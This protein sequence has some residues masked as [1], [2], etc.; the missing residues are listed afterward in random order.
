MELA[1]RNRT[2]KSSAGCSALEVFA[3]DPAVSLVQAYLRLNGFFT[4]TE[5]PVMARS[6]RGTF[7]MTD[8]DIL[9]VRFPNAQH[10]IPGEGVPAAQLGRDRALEIDSQSMQL[11]IGEVKEGRAWINRGALRPRVL[12]T[13]VRRF[14]CCEENPRKIAAQIL[15]EGSVETT[16]NG[17]PC[18]V[19]LL[20]FG[21]VQDEH[22]P[23]KYT[24]IPLRHVIEYTNEYVSRYSDVFT[25]SEMKDEGLSLITLMAKLG[26][27]VGCDPASENISLH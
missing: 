20:V 14:G 19:R 4:V 23:S 18:R 9:A 12:E 6:P 22:H 27:R 13:V 10:W 16:V 5:F 21:G 1:R 25:S 17:M 15:D 7:S 3:I 2:R 24:C 26:M 8:I 11:I